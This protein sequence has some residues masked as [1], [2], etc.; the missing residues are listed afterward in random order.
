[1]LLTHRPSCASALQYMTPPK[2]S[3]LI[4]TISEMAISAPEYFPIVNFNKVDTALARR[5]VVSKQFL[6]LLRR[7][8]NSLL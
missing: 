2:E 4:T 3:Q 6:K 8:V 5:R 7:G 1:M